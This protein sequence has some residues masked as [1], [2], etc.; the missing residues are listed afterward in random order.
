M[1]KGLRA[2]VYSLWRPYFDCGGCGMVLSGPA[3]ALRQRQASVDEHG[4]DQ[5]STAWRQCETV[6]MGASATPDV[7][8]DEL[9]T[10]NVNNHNAL[11]ASSR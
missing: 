4:R 9:P 7:T 2:G 11:A 8:P 1:P 3:A 10:A 5:A 6:A